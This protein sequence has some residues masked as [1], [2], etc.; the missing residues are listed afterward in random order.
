MT[1]LLLTDNICLTMNRRG[2]VNRNEYVGDSVGCRYQVVYVCIIDMDGCCSSW[3]HYESRT[4]GACYERRAAIAIA[5]TF[6]SA[7]VIGTGTLSFMQHTCVMLKCRSC[8]H[9]HNKGG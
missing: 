9:K 8:A 5:V 1:I 3:G 6:F 2:R 4:G 7:I